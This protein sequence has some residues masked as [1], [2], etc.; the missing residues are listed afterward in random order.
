MS[1]PWLATVYLDSKQQA[2]FSTAGVFPALPLCVCVCV[3]AGQGLQSLVRV[4][5]NYQ[6]INCL[7]VA[8]ATKTLPVLQK[9]LHQFIAFQ[10]GESPCYRKCTIAVCRRVCSVPAC[11]M[12]SALPHAC[13]TSNVSW[14]GCTAQS[15]G[16]SIGCDTLCC[17]RAADPIH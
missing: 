9:V 14:C 5:I 11:E 16:D 6:L 1:S 12:R 3:F 10:G 2:A 13:L 8:S 15:G 7:S 4:I 17:G